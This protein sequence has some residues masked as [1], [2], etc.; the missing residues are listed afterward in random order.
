[1]ETTLFLSKILG[2]V[3]LVRGLSVIIDRGHFRGMLDRFEEEVNTLAFSFFPIALLMSCIALALI[4]DDT[5]SLAGVFIQVIAWGGIVKAV[6]L[7]LFPALIAKKARLL[8]QFGFI[9][10][11]WIVCFGVGGY[12]TWFGYFN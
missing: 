7:I 8:G 5:S 12:F 10:V 11:V 3:L 2:P 6:A 1:M 4:H 9:H